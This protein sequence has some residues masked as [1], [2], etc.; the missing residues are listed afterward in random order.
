MLQFGLHGA[1]EPSPPGTEKV[2]DSMGAMKKT[3][4]PPGPIS[5]LAHA[6]PAAHESGGDA[7]LD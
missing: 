3:V 2:G 4:P 7:K 5:P 1:A 6:P